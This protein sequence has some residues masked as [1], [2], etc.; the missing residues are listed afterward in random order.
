MTDFDWYTTGIWHHGIRITTFFRCCVGSDC[1]LLEVGSD[2]VLLEV[3]SDCVLSE[4]G[5]DCVLSEVGSDC[6][7]SEV[8]SDCDLLEVGGWR[9]VPIAFCRRLDL[10]GWLQG[11]ALTRACMKL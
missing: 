9:L 6:V 3:G 10:W 11:E 7:L 1:I 4:V 2:C 5:S 8:G